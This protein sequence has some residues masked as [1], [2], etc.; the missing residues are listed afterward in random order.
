[1]HGPRDARDD[2]QLLSGIFINK[3]K[4]HIGHFLKYLFF[5]QFF[6]EKIHTS[7]THEIHHWMQF[8]NHLSMFSLK[9][10]SKNKFSKNSELNS[11]TLIEIQLLPNLTVTPQKPLPTITATK[12][13][14]MLRNWHKM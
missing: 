9:I 3:C 12:P 4:G 6:L 13:K 11:I 1:M 14:Q 2:E 8:L 7:L 10:N 5:D